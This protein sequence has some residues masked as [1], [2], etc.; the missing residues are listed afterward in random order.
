[1]GITDSVSL[2]LTT[3]TSCTHWDTLWVGADVPLY[4]MCF[5]DTLKGWAV[6]DLGT[7]MKTYDGGRSWSRIY[8]DSSVNLRYVTA[9][10]SLHIFALADQVQDPEFN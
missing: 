10:D 6:G 4:S 5:T 2:I 1:M 3:D 8:R 9:V 7:I